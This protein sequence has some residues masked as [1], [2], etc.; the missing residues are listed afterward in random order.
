MSSYSLWDFINLTPS[1]FSMLDELKQQD[2]NH[3]EGLVHVDDAIFLVR[4]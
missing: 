4:L 3:L 2:E 1:Y